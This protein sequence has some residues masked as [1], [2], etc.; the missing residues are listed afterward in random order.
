MRQ[1]KWHMESE[2]R[3]LGRPMDGGEQVNKGVRIRNLFSEAN[4]SGKEPAV[5][6]SKPPGMCVLWRKPRSVEL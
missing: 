3:L 2:L 6:T 1:S 5:P 4:N